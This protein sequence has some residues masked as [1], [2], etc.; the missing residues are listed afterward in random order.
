M[1]PYTLAEV[2]QALVL[3]PPDNQCHALATHMA[4]LVSPPVVS[5]LAPPT[6]YP[7]PLS[8]HQANPPITNPPITPSPYPTFDIKNTP[9]YPAPQ[10]NPPFTPS[11]HLTFNITI[12]LLHLSATPGSTLHIF[13]HSQVNPLI[14][15]LIFQWSPNQ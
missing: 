9:S 3:Q 13:I 7:A 2:L 14:S 15:S 12:I 11:T 6:P 8:I 1:T 10:A 5:A 4:S